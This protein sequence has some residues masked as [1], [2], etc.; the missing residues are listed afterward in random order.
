MYPI[1][2]IRD[3]IYSHNESQMFK[4]YLQGLTLVSNFTVIRNI[5]D[6]IERLCQLDVEFNSDKKFSFAYLIEENGG[7]D[8]LEGLQQHP[9][10][11]IYKRVVNLLETYFG[12]ESCN[13]VSNMNNNNNNQIVNAAPTNQQFVI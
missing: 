4:R 3:L 13:D 10:E 11:E 6:S 8:L 9:N 5:L 7:V 1:D 2:K 12:A